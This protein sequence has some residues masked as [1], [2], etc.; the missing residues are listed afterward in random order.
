MLFGFDPNYNSEL[1][2]SR[3][4]KRVYNSLKAMKKGFIKDAGHSLV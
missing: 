1:N 4:F 2:L 3:N